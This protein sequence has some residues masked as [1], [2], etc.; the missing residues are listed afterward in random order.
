MALVTPTSSIYASNMALYNKPHNVQLIY[1]IDTQSIPL[2]QLLRD[3]DLVTIKPNIFNLKRLM[4][5]EKM[6]INADVYMGHFELDGMLVYKNL[7][8]DKSMM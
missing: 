4:R 7:L 6:T 2:I 8:L 5:G 1:K 3:N